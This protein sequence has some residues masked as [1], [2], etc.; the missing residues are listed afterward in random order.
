LRSEDI[1]RYKLRH[2]VWVPCWELFNGVWTPMWWWLKTQRPLPQPRGGLVISYQYY[3]EHK[4]VFD[5]FH[6]Q[7]DRVASAAID[8]ARQDRLSVVSRSYTPEEFDAHYYLTPGP[9]SSMPEV[10]DYWDNF[11]EDMRRM[12]RETDRRWTREVAEAVNRIGGDDS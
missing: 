7:A 12:A 6:A 1:P 2:G 3:V 10:D 4:A 9:V 11:R 8:D 5:E